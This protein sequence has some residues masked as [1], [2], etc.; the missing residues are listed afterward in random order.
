M[1]LSAEGCGQERQV[2]WRSQQVWTVALATEQLIQTSSLKNMCDDRWLAFSV[3]CFLSLS[4]PASRSRRFQSIER[5]KASSPTRSHF[6]S[7]GKKRSNVVV[8]VFEFILHRQYLLFVLSFIEIKT[9]H[10]WWSKKSWN[11]EESSD[12]RVMH[13]E[14]TKVDS[15]GDNVLNECCKTSYTNRITWPR[16]RQTDI[17]RETRREREIIAQNFEY[18][19]VS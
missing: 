5:E 2:K 17:E 9:T 16:D 6:S 3:G 4:L 7:R 19:R 10:A 14:K 15:K 11:W 1:L 12:N 18:E 13:R 8:V